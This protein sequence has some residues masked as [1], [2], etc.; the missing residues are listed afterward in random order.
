MLSAS[1]GSSTVEVA[2]TND[3]DD[4]KAAMR[5]FEAALEY[6]ERA[7]SLGGFKLPG[8]I[9]QD[10]LNLLLLLRIRD[11]NDERADAEGHAEAILNL[12][13][14][15]NDILTSVS[16]LRWFQV[17]ALADSGAADASRRMALAAVAEDAKLTNDPDYWEIGRRQYGLLR[18]FLEQYAQVL[19]HPSLMGAVSQILQIGGD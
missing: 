2:A 4:L 3:E 17:I 18:R 8:L 16:Y 9:A 7:R 15:P 1:G 14:R 6:M 11:E 13:P 10:R 12:K 5:D 19:R